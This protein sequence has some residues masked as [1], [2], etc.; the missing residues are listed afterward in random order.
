MLVLFVFVVVLIG[1]FMVLKYD[2]FVVLIDMVYFLGVVYVELVVVMFDDVIMVEI[3]W[4][5]FFCDLLL[6]QLIGIL[7]ENNCDMC[8][9]V[10]NVEVVQVLY[11]IQCVE[12]LLNLGVF[13]CGVLECV[14]VDF[15]IM[16]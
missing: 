12:M 7:L 15:S 6:Q 11:C 9:V 1:C 4:W 16:G 8:K 5:D 14:L 13:V 2:W 10:F 3:G